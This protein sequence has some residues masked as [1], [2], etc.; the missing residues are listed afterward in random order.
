MITEFANILL[1]LIYGALFVALSL[2]VARALRPDRPDPV[3]L[4]IYE[5]GEEPIGSARVRFNNRFY[6][7]AL[8]FLIF[9]VEVLLLFPLAV[10]FEGIGWYAFWAMFVFVFLI[11]IG[12][13][14][15][16][17]KGHLEWDKPQPVVPG[18]V[19]HVGVVMEAGG[20]D[21]IPSNPARSAGEVKAGAVQKQQ[22]E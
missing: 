2:L 13:V 14:Y 8:M 6:I 20:Y 18:Y 1:F 21:T 4:S 9:E 16:F 12:F 5:C 11:F 3:K 10:V 17:G 22:G 7:I 15:E 19:D